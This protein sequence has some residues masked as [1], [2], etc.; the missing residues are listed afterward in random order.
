ME[1]SIPIISSLTHRG[2]AAAALRCRSSERKGARCRSG[3]TRAPAASQALLGHLCPLYEVAG[4]QQGWAGGPGLYW[5]L[6]WHQCCGRGPP[7]PCPHLSPFRGSCW[8]RGSCHPPCSWY[9]VINA[10]ERV[11]TAVRRKGFTVIEGLKVQWW[12]Q[13]TWLPQ[14]TLCPLSLNLLILCRESVPY[15][16]KAVVRLNSVLMGT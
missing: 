7:Q 8:V 11:G 6:G 1:T 12:V 3:V 14:M 15:T 10:F 16:R 2:I 5:N 4:L 9:P 13:I